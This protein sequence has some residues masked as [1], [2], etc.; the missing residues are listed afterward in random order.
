MA[1]RVKVLVPTALRQFAGGKEEVSCGGGTVGEVLT[2]LTSEYGDLKQHLYKENGQLRNFVNIY[3]ND[4]DVR[5][6]EREATEVS[7]GDTITIVPA[8]AGGVAEAATEEITLSPEE[9]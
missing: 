7:D 4:E 2:S 6:L 5:Y 3:L 9:I 8:I 1:N